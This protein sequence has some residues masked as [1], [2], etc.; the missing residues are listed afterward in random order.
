MPYLL[1]QNDTNKKTNHH[2]NNIISN[3]LVR[4]QAKNKTDN[5]T[6]IESKTFYI[7]D[8]NEGKKIHK[9]F[10]CFL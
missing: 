6:A 9:N 5:I 1:L 8:T 4:H 2:P 3:I 7:H 10:Q